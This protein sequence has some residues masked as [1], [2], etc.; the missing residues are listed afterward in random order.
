MINRQSWGLPH[1]CHTSLLH[2]TAALDSV[3]N[4]VCDRS[5]R[6][7]NSA[8]NSNSIILQ[9]VF[10]QSSKLWLTVLLATTVFMDGSTVNFIL[11]KIQFL[12]ALCE[13][14]WHIPCTQQCRPSC[15]LCITYIS[16]IYKFILLS[17]ALLS[18]S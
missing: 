13:M 5:L 8:I 4:V 1:R 6:L 11:N 7:V 2:L 16:H 15:L 18:S 9:D 14:S 12:P 10:Y 17:H 3:F